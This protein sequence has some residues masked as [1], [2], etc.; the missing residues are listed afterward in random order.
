MAIL[1]R[2]TSAAAAATAGPSSTLLATTFRRARGCGRLLPAA[3]RL[4]RAFAARASAQPLEVCA[5]E[6]ITVPGR[7]GDCPFT[8]RV[9]LTIEEKHLP[10]DL[11][12]VDL[13][14][15][16]DWLFEMNPEGKVPIVK[17]E[18]KWIADSDVITQALEE[19]YP[20]PPLATPLDKASVG[21]KIFSTFIGF[22]K[23]KD[24]SDGTEQALLD[25]LTSFDSYLKD[26]GPFINGGT[27]SAADLSLGP[28][29]YHMEIALGHYKNWS[30]PD[31]LS[32]VKQYMKS[33]FSMDSFVKT[34][35]LPEDVI[36]GWR[37]KVMG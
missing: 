31:S 8:Q 27:I 20:E 30:V 24:P 7:L 25:E 33:I 9:L 26:N 14:N 11:K 32:H 28:K 12:L 13:A 19:K 29:L 4:R 18:D 34:R 16:P 1:L 2:G 10:Y 21:S 37:P 36:A 35:A 22:L 15:K 23:S 6:S 3:P 5:K 17:L